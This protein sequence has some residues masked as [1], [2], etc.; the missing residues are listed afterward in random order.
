MSKPIPTGLNETDWA[1]IRKLVQDGTSALYDDMDI[2]TDYWYTKGQVQ[3]MLVKIGIEPEIILKQVYN[4]YEN[5]D[6]DEYEE[7][8]YEDEDKDNWDVY[9]SI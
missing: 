9:S 2:K 8:Y 3:E 4:H 1:I 7:D 6:I 5:E